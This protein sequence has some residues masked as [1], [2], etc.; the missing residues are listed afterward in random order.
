MIAT[1]DEAR[2]ALRG[3]LDVR[4]RAGVNKVAPVCVYDLAQRLGLEVRFAGGGSFGGMYE[5]RSQTVVVPALRPPGRRAYSC[6][7]E[8]GHWYFRHG[9]RVDR[10]EDFEQIQE[11]APEER[12]ANLFG[13][14]LLMPQWAVEAQFDA[15]GWEPP[16]ATAMQIYVVAGVLGVGYATLVQHLCWSLQLLDHSRLEDLLR[17]TPKQLRSVLLGDDAASHIIAA[18]RDWPMHL[19]IDL[20]VG[21]GAIVPHDAEIDGN[22]AVVRGTV[23]SG[24]L[25]LATAPGVSRI[26]SACERWSV[27]LRVSRRDFIGRSIYRHLE[28]CDVNEIA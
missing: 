26:E 24:R 17:T 19:P 20:Q 2:E 27:F 5:R 10:A 9:T 23:D 28:D 6:A 25:V 11:R 12:L 13:G 4:R 14:Y 3:A 7:H 21:E 16:S 18:D 22:T 15:R 8:M 1:R